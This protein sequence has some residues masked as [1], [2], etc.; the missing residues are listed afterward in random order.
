[1][2]SARGFTLIEMMVAVALVGI[3]MAATLPG[4]AGFLNG[5]KMNMTANNIYTAMQ[6]TKSSA[7]QQNARMTLVLD[8]S[9]GNWCI[10]NRTVEPDS[11]TCSWTSNTMESGVVRKYIEPLSNGIEM[12]A[13]PSDATQITYDGLGRVVPNPD[14]SA[15]ITSIAVTMPNDETRANTVQLSN[16]IVR[17]CDPLKS[18]G[19]PQ[20]C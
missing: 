7:I 19:D 1:M 14:A 11:T 12:A 2:N 3:I 9:K 16:G 17:L 15:I 20:A 18:V 10:F 5:Q 13:V 8:T 6:I 4:F